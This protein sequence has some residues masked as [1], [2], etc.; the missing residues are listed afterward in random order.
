MVATA[1]VQVPAGHYDP[2]QSGFWTDHWSYT[3]DHLNTYLSVFPDKKEWLLYD[4]PRLPFFFSDA[5]V[6]PRKDKYTIGTTGD[7][8]Q[9]N[10][11]IVTGPKAD[12]VNIIK[13]QPNYVSDGQTGG[14][15]QLDQW[16]NTFSVTVISK[17]V[18]LTLTKFCLLDP[19]GMGLEMEA[20]KPGW[21]DA[22]NGLPGLI[23]SE[24]PA[25]HELHQLIKFVGQSVD[26]LER[27]VAIPSELDMLLRVVDQEIRSFNNDMNYWDGVRTA[28]EAYRKQTA[29]TFDGHLVHWNPAQL[30]LSTGV[31]GRMLERSQAGIDK[32]VTFGRDGV[33]TPTYFY[34][35]A[36]EFDTYGNGIRVTRFE[37]VTLPLFLEGPVRLMKTLQSNQQRE[38][39]YAAVKTSNLYDSKLSLYKISESLVGQPFE[40]GRMMAF[41]PG[42][43]ENESV[44]THMSYKWYLELLRAGLYDQFFEEMKKGIVCFMNPNRFGRSPLEAASF[45]VSSAFPDS[46]LHGSGFLARLSGSTAE[47]LSIWNLMMTG[48]KPFTMP[49]SSQGLVL[50]LQPLLP[51]WLWGNEGTVSFTFLGCVKV[52]YHNP[53][54]SHTWGKNAP[55]IYK[56]VLSKADGISVTLAGPVIKEPYASSVRDKQYVAINIYFE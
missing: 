1:S 8:R 21:N 9:Y 6:M 10:A 39:L 24:M 52:T 45:I 40:V 55:I 22:M 19:M 16:G 30:G 20:G 50:A 42:W 28:L 34:F 36:A 46:D 37:L 51:D 32:A 3:L 53:A 47:F 7:V 49:S 56:S 35:K 54:K 4:S 2:A 15:W 25:A 11:A 44:W 41:Q 31:L 23:G 17:M 38:A 14:T 13:A 27:S 29:L 5:I 12:Q 48:P 26:E 18:L 33:V 43:L